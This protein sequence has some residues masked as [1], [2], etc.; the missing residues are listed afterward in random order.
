[1]SDKSYDD[2]SQKSD[3]AEKS[4]KRRKRNIIILEQPSSP[5]RLAN[6]SILNSSFSSITR[7]D[8]P[9]PT[10][11]AASSN[12]AILDVIH[13][14]SDS[15]DESNLILRPATDTT[16][17]LKSNTTKVAS[18]TNKASVTTDHVMAVDLRIAELSDSIESSSPLQ[19]SPKK[20]VQI[21]RKVVQ[22]AKKR[23][24]DPLPMEPYSKKELNEANKVT[25]KKEELL[26]EM[27]IQIPSLLYESDF[28][29]EYMKQIFVEPKVE[30][31]NSNLPIISWKRKVKARYNAERDVFIP[32]EPTEINEKNI[33]IYYKAKEFVN[34][35]IEGTISL[36]VDACKAEAKHHN[37]SSGSHIIIIVEGY[38]QFLTK[39]R[40]MEDKRYK[41][42]VLDKLNPND[43]N[44]GN[45]RLKKQ[46]DSVS[47]SP[48]EIDQ[49]VNETQ[50]RL[51]VNVFPVKNNKDAINWLQSFTY[52]IAYALYDKFE[53][54]ISLANLGTVKSGTDTKSTYFQTVKQFRLMTEPK[55]EKL[56]GFY[57]SIFALYSR[58]QTND[59]LGKDNFGKNIVPPSTE[60]AMK[61]LFTSDDPNDVVHE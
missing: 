34:S 37:L 45:K 12:T 57:T 15:G 20:S 28:E 50:V 6:T 36:F 3:N 4:V 7:E 10:N 18:F 58:F 23:G 31:T 1:M 53:R 24:R 32:C 33:V 39:I 27:V 22:P 35:L 49:L 41:K 17:A 46:E 25:R 48:K 51:N 54:N 16:N 13:W 9:E 47:L 19:S 52:T 43:D 11:T 26:S 30:K 2:S 59:T 42:A 61:K 55:V 44:T 21:H 40:N 29:N 60:S 8:E 56:Y 5:D 14:L 38:V